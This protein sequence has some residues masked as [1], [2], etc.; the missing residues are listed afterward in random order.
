MTGWYREQFWLETKRRLLALR[1]NQHCSLLMPMVGG[2]LSVMDLVKLCL[3]DDPN[4]R[5]APREA[6]KSLNAIPDGKSRLSN[7]FMNPRSNISI[8]KGE[9][10][11]LNTSSKSKRGLMLQPRPAISIKRKWCPGVSFD[12]KDKDSQRN[13]NF[14]PM[15][16]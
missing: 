12:S 3:S 2:I 9:N 10:S 7:S 13:V 1:I 5:P 6:L 4:S 11:I 8:E 16:E 15:E 14:A